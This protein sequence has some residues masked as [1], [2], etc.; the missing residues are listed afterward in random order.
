MLSRYEY[1]AMLV[2]ASLTYFNNPFQIPLTWESALMLIE[3]VHP[4]HMPSIDDAKSPQVTPEV[5]NACIK[6]KFLKWLTYVCYTC[7]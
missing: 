5:S 6:Y 2:V 7:M 1:R 3:Y 4:S